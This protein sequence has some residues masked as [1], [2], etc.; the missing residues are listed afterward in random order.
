M[1]QLLLRCGAP[2][3]LLGGSMAV[4]G[5]DAFVAL[6]KAIAFQQIS[7]K[8]GQTIWTRVLD[9]VGGAG[10]MTPAAIAA[11]SVDELRAAG[12]SG[13]KVEYVKD[14]SLHF[15][16]GQLSTHSLL[17]MDDEAATAALTRV[18]GI[19]VWSAHMYLIFGL[20]RSDV[21]AWGDYGIRKAFRAEYGGS[22][23]SMPERA[24]I[25]TKAAAWAP[26]RTLACWALWRSLD[27][28]KAEAAAAAAP[29]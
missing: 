6:A 27:L 21:L 1:A 3:S 5:E 26:H 25:E 4:T 10:K 17:S 29:R 2:T 24:E 14:L 9:V 20:N 16:S 15:S 12:L 11:A 28:G 19:G 18:R 23:N 13:R 22:P 7:T 8:A